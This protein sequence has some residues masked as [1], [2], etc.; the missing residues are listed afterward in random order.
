MA[1]S[2]AP[3]SPLTV[4][5]VGEESVESLYS[6]T[7]LALPRESACE[8]D[9]GPVRV[10][11]YALNLG[12]AQPESLE[13]SIPRFGG[14]RDVVAVTLLR[15]SYRCSAELLN[16]ARRAYARGDGS[17]R[18][19]AEAP[20]SHSPHRDAA[21]GPSRAW[22]WDDDDSNELCADVYPESAAVT[23]EDVLRESGEGNAMIRLL[24]DVV[25][26]HSHY[27]RPSSEVGE[28]EVAYMQL[29]TRC[30]LSGLEQR[31]LD[32]LA[33][34]HGLRKAAEHLHDPEAK[35]LERAR[36][37]D[38][39]SRCLH[40]CS[41]EYLKVLERAPHC[42]GAWYGLGLVQRSLGD[43]QGRKRVRNSQLQ[44]LLSR[45]FPTRFG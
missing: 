14:D 38:K 13:A 9:L 41:C 34:A 3:Q 1:A 15:S 40:E 17:G 32:C 6:G 39:R 5:S 8:E 44:R 16:K 36:H 26:R 10:G 42:L 37:A 24:A 4:S 12:G 19:F 31:A 33:R 25:E 29:S 2:S 18:E 21:L 28:D 22:S 27:G 11:C 43:H 30:R 23:R 7:S 20:G 35:S 45:S